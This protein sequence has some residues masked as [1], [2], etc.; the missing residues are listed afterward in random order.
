[1]QPQYNISRVSLALVFAPVLLALLAAAI[2]SYYQFY[3][4]PQVSL[5]EVFSYF[6]LFLKQDWQAIIGV[7]VW[8]LFILVPFS[9]FLKRVNKLRLTIFLPGAYFIGSL[10]AFIVILS[11]KEIQVQI[12]MIPSAVMFSFFVGGTYAFFQASLSWFMAGFH[13]QDEAQ[14]HA[15]AH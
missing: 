4:K 15:T 2:L 1:M 11:M 7:Y 8:H 9:L 5:Q 12:Y 13:L 3:H 6:Y 14:Y 10:V